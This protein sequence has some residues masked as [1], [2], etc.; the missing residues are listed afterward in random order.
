MGARL[1]IGSQQWPLKPGFRASDLPNSDWAQAVG[2]AV[3]RWFSVAEVVAFRTSGST[4]VPKEVVHQKEAMQ[5]S[6]ERT[7]EALDLRAGTTAWLAM[8]VEF[9]GG[10][11]MVVRAIVGEWTLVASEPRVNLIAP[12]GIDFVALTPLQARENRSELQKVKKVLLGGAPAGGSDWG[13]EEVWESFGMT[14]T[15]SHIAL[16]KL[17]PGGANPA[18]E[19]VRDVTVA[20]NE[21]G[22]LTIEA[23]HLFSGK[24]VTRDEVEVLSPRCFLWKGRTDEVINTGGLK[25]HPSEVEAAA[26]EVVDVPCVAF[27]L[28]HE[29]LGEQVVLA[30]HGQG[31]EEEAEKIRLRLVELLPRHH[32]PKRVEYRT[33]E[34]TPSGKWIRPH[35]H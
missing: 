27:G 3:E 33:L 7:I 21:I 30:L 1:V 2:R 22:C 14:E 29:T 4:G 10:F 8:P 31:T 16:R 24:L 19:T 15:V 17:K 25:V 20:A 26:R 11:M 5:A 23:P 9:V 18:F 28:P 34:Q 12:E 13:G 35:Q 32:A 6:A